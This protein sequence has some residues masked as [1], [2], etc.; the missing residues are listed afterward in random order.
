[1]KGTSKISFSGL[2]AVAAVLVLIA[3]AALVLSRMHDLVRLGKPGIK[4][5]QREV[6][7]ETG[8]VVATNAVDFPKVPGYSMTNLPVDRI[9]VDLLPRDTTFGRAHYEATNG[10]STTLHAVLM[11]NDRTSIHKPEI[12]LVSQGLR[13]EDRQITSI[14]IQEPVPYDLPVTLLTTT[15][16]FKQ[17]DGQM[18]H[19]RF[20]Y[21]YWFVADGEVTADHK[22]RMARMALRLIKTGELQRWAYISCLAD[23]EVGREAELL[24]EM[25]KLIAAAVPQFQLATGTPLRLAAKP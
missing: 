3:G 21:L 14:P 24:V 20:L 18:G 25:Q 13:I 11:G 16:E 17:P 2:A 23:C 12:C 5:V 8:K 1:M 15:G 19:R 7:D 10:F 6:H 4:V 22:Q 9:V